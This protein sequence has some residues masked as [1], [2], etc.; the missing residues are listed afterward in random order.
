MIGRTVDCAGTHK[1]TTGMMKFRP[2]NRIGTG[3]CRCVD[4]RGLLSSR[5][6][7]LQTLNGPG[8]NIG[9]GESAHRRFYQCSHQQNQPPSL[10]EEHFSNPPM[11]DKGD[12]S[13]ASTN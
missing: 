3:Y 12:N 6:V 13:L 8:F 10:M 4:A 1:K 7:Y 11:D 5:M 9:T 2:R